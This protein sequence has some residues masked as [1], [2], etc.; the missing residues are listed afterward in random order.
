MQGFSIVI[1]KRHASDIFCCQETYK[2]HTLTH[3]RGLNSLM[4]FEWIL[5]LPCIRL[6][7][8]TSTGC[9]LNPGIL[10]PSIASS[11]MHPR[12]CMSGWLWLSTMTTTTQI[13]PSDTPYRGFFCLSVYDF[14]LW[15]LIRQLFFVWQLLRLPLGYYYRL[16][17]VCLL[18]GILLPLLTT[19]TPVTTGDI[20]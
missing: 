1:N 8:N 10:H 5:C 17:L 11:L 12:R 18:L 3:Y 14:L 20:N 2:R 13:Y 19:A 16:L 6:T 7:L 4:L 9:M 15:Q